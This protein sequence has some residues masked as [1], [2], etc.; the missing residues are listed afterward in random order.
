MPS[1]QEQPQKIKAEQTFPGLLTPW[2]AIC[3]TFLLTAATA[4]RADDGGISYG[5]GKKVPTKVVPTN[6]RSLDGQAK[7]VTCKGQ[8][9]CLSKYIYT[10]RSARL[11]TII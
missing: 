7:N 8:S 9:D 10:C 4:A 2:L 3:L 1:C 6:D 11:K 5:D